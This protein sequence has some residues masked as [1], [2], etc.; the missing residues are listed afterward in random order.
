MIRRLRYGVSIAIAPQLTVLLCLCTAPDLATAR[1]LAKAVVEARLAACVSLLP[2][3]QS[4]Y[5]WQGQIECREEV[6]LLIK[7][8]HHCLAALQSRIC[9]IHPDE[10]PELIAVEAAGGLPAYLDWVASETRTDD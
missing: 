5:R 2:G 6:Q 9:A 4:V 7:T 10:L 3:M 1:T 8:T